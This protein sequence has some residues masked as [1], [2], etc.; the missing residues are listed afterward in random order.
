MDIPKFSL[1]STKI[2]IFYGSLVYL[3]IEIETNKGSYEMG[4]VK[5]KGGSGVNKYEKGGKVSTA[6]RIKRA[7]TKENEDGTWDA[8]VY[9]DTPTEQ[10]GGEGGG[11]RRMYKGESTNM[12]NQR[13]ARE[14]ALNRAMGKTVSSPADSV[15]T[16]GPEKFK[17]IKEPPKK[18]DTKKKTKKKKGF[19][20][21]RK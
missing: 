11:K 7:S 18:T 1:K 14:R 13:R 19:F 8:T 12:Y 5:D 2:F 6:V 10:V 3:D 17:K 4:W 21:R 9:V 15:I 20:K 16:G